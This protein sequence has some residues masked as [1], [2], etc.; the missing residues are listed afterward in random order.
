MD[1]MHSNPLSSLPGIHQIQSLWSTLDT[2]TNIFQ[3]LYHLEN[4]WNMKQLEDVAIIHK[5]P[6]IK[7]I[8]K[9]SRS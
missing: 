1:Q 5:P 2:T 6:E 8:G 4:L 7:V 9:S 3:H